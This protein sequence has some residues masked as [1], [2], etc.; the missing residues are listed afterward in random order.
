MEHN[1]FVILRTQSGSFTP[2]TD[3]DDEEKIAK[4]ATKEAAKSAGNTSVLGAYFGYEVFEMG[5][6]D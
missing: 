5:T 2:M 6:G 1:F 4:F 3:K